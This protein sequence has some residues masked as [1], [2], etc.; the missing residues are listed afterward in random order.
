MRNFLRWMEREHG[1]G[2]TFIVMMIMV[3]LVV[4]VIIFSF[5]LLGDYAFVLW[6]LVAVLYLGKYVYEYNFSRKNDL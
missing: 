4:S 6:L 5:I 3:F 2:P 1:E